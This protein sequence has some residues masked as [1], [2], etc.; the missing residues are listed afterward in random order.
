MIYLKEALTK[1]Q[2]ILNNLDF[3]RE[4]QKSFLAMGQEVSYRIVNQLNVIRARQTNRS[5]H[6][7]F[8]SDAGFK[9]PAHR[10]V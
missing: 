8:A 2:E 10:H 4:L 6:K 3:A 7:M 9:R 5:S 1:Y